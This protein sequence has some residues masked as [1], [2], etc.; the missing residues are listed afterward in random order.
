[1]NTRRIEAVGAKSSGADSMNADSMNE[2]RLRAARKR[3]ADSRDQEDAIDGLREI[4]GAF[5]GSEEMGLFTVDRRTASFRVFWSFG[6]DLENYDLQKALGD[7]GH[8]R[9]MRGECHINLSGRDHTG[10]GLA[11]AFV[12][13]IVAKQTI[14]IVAILRLLPQKTAFDRSDFE[15]FNL[16]SNEAGPLLFGRDIASAARSDGPEMRA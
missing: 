1:M 2:A 6:I 15:L 16:L 7:T 14:A 8:Q 10:K 5:L 13:I 9:V 4:V 11:Q 12:P 3:L